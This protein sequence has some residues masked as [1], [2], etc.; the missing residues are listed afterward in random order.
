MKKTLIKTSF[1]TFVVGDL[2]TTILA[3]SEFP[4]AIAESNQVVLMLLD[5]FGLGILIPLKLAVFAG[6]YAVF[7]SIDHK[8]SV[9]IPISLS[10]MG[11]VITISNT[12]ILLKV[13]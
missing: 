8:F 12:L 9:A 3:L 10:V 2:V 5:S 4:H 7:G 6:A 1:S 13:I 11:V